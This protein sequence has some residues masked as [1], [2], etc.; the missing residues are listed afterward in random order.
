MSS[1]FVLSCV[2]I[3]PDGNS[4]KQ[5]EVLSEK[6]RMWIEKIGQGNFLPW[7]KLLS[8]KT[9]LLPSLYYPLPCVPFSEKDCDDI[10]DPRLPLIKGLHGVSHSC[11]SDLVHLPSS[12][13]GLDIPN[14]FFTS[15]T[16]RMN[17]LTA[18]LKCDNKLG[19][20]FRI[21]IETQKLEA[22]IS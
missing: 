2:H 13:G 16:K 5:K 14:M 21:L 22:G 4:K 8:L 11:P 15:L 1:L 10:F 19:K 6:V 17:I 7:Q 9:Q 18:I 3:S 12:H 20:C